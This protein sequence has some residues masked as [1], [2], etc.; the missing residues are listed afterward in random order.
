MWPLTKTGPCILGIAARCAGS[1]PAVARRRRAPSPALAPTTCEAPPF[2]PM[3]RWPSRGSRAI[4][5]LQ[6]GGTK[7]LPRHPFT[8]TAQR[9][10]W[11]ANVAR[12]N[13][14]A[15]ELAPVIAELRSAGI[16]SKKGLAKTLNERAIRT[17]RGIGRWRAI[18]VARV[19]ARLPA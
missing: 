2:G 3:P 8:P 18:Q 16:T 17:P 5:P 1:C 13:Q 11:E 14:R 6:S 19:L 4:L 9:A 15:A 7:V 12:A 10:G